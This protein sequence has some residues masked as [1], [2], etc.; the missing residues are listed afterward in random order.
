M[1]DFK[2]ITAPFDG[3]ITARRIDVGALVSATN[4]SNNLALFDVA[5]TK[6]MRVYVRAPQVNAASMHAGMKVS[7]TLPQYPGRSFEGAIDTTSSAISDTSRA[8]LVEAIFDNRDGLLTPGAYAEAHFHLPLDPHKLVIPS[9]AMIF[10]NLGPEVAAVKDNKITLKP[11]KILVDL[12]PQIEISSGLDPED[13]LVASPSDAMED[14]EAVEVTKIDGKAL[15]AKP[16]AQ[17]R[18]PRHEAS[19]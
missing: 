5:A 7:L 8:L 11:I 4:T 15:N 9:S 18:E 10:R 16:L 1:E 3:I 13:K 12:G 17:T 19:K 6:Q 2:N 14:G